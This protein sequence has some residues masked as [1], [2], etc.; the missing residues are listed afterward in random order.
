MRHLSEATARFKETKVQPKQTNVELLTAAGI[1]EVE[2]FSEHD[3]K[4][5]E[6]ITPDEIEVL[7]RLKKKLGM[8]TAKVAGGMRPNFP[9]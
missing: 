7:I 1:L 5:I 4:V 8:A 9:V 2:H 6:T 3:K